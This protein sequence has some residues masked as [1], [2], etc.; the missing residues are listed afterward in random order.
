VTSLSLPPENAI[1]D[2]ASLPLPPCT[3]MANIRLLKPPPPYQTMSGLTLLLLIGVFLSST[4]AFISPSY[5][6]LAF[7]QQAAPADAS[8]RLSFGFP[9]TRFAIPN[10]PD[11]AQGTA[12]EDE[13]N[14][15]AIDLGDD[16]WR[17]FRAKLVMQGDAAAS[18]AAPSSSTTTSPLQDEGDLDGIGTLFQSEPSAALFKSAAQ[19]SII[20]AD[21]TPLDPSQWA[22]DSGMVIEQGAVILGGVEQDFGFGL[23]QQYFHKAAILVLDHDESTFTKG[24]ILNRPTDL[25]LDDDINLGVKWRVWFGGDVQGLASGNPDIVCLH[26]LKNKK[27]TKASVPVMKDMQWTTF[28]NAKRLVQVGAAKP[29][30]FW[31]FCGYAGWGPQQLIGELERKSWYMV[32]TD[33][34]TLLKELAR[35]SAGA[36]PR[37]AGLETWTLLMQMIGREETAEEYSGDFDDLMLKEW[38]LKNLLSTEAGGGAGEKRLAPEGV[39]STQELLQSDPVDRLLT[40][41]SAASRGEDMAEGTIVRASSAD[42][43]PFLLED[44]ELHRSVVLIIS[45]DENISVGVILNRPA[46]K[47]LDIQITEKETGERKTIAVPIRFGGQYAVKG[48]EPLLWLHCS[49]IL[50]AAKVGCPV[51]VQEGCF[52]K[53]TADDVISAVSKGLAT[54]DD[55]MVISGVSV[56]TK[57]EGGLARGMQG[58]I[59]AGKFEPI[60]PA[61]NEAV[62]DALAKQNILTNQNLVRNLVVAED[63][64]AVGAPSKRERTNGD[65]EAPSTPIGGLGE[66][67]DEEDDSLVF[68]SDFK[69]AN[70]SNDALRSWVATF[71]L[72]A[73]TL[74]A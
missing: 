15:S 69:V 74:G 54:P 24:I 6:Q 4:A 21:M 61:K 42:R 39:A 13:E 28:D 59:R 63:A 29:T 56:W 71:L 67:F 20:S 19:T 58:E 68:K 8:S 25:M 1:C 43:S 44:Q 3:M 41:V 65:S 5:N 51:G 48:S 73:P 12:D 49:P 17:A 52:W 66:G 62:W 60:P 18:P 38:A 55:F 32:A 37:D 10:D 31:V 64:W 2:L 50:R 46:A 70:L 22:Y 53:C 23:R 40:R 57:G 14:E 11:W 34:Q 30:D 33:S 26:S 45:D 16:D 27:A 36:E 47:G 7:K 72:G 9:T 35:Q